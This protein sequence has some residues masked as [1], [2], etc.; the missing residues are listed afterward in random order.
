MRYSPTDTK[1]EAILY[2]NWRRVMPW[3]IIHCLTT[4]C[5]SDSGVFE[6][7]SVS[8]GRD[9]LLAAAGKEGE[10]ARLRKGRVG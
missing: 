9:V 8:Q 7:I 6:V 5:Y 3:G 4:A 10:G 1:A 2:R